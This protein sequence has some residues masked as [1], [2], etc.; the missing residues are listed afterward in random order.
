MH[1]KQSPHVK[2]KIAAGYILLAAV[3]C[4]AILYVLFEV[5][6][7]GQGDG[8]RQ[9]LH[10]RR[11]IVSRILYHLYQAESYGQLMT[12]GY[13][14][15]E[16]RYAREIRTVRGYLDSLRSVTADSV[17]MLRLDSIEYLVGQKERST[18][19]M[20]NS[21]VAGATS[22][23]LAENIERLL[24]AD[25]LFAEPVVRPDTV[26]RS[27][28]VR[29]RRKRR[30]F[31]RRLGDLF[32]PPREETGVVVST[33]IRI[34]TLPAVTDTI[35]GVLRTLEQRVTDQRL[36]IYEQAWKEGLRLR[37]SNRLVNE[38]IFRLI[39]AYE[40]DETAYLTARYL[41]A[42]AL[43]HRSS[44]VLG[45]IAAVSILLMLLFVAILWR[46]IGRANRYKRQIEEAN[47]TNEALIAA[48]EQMMRTIT[49]DIK[50]PLGSIMGYID[51][52][53]RLTGG[54][55][56][57]LYLEH[58]RSSADH[59]LALVNDLLD[60]Y[61]LEANKVETHSVPFDPRQ[62]FA[63]IAAEFAPQA[64]A[65]GIALRTELPAGG[66]FLAGDPFRIRQ[67]A[68]N[69]LSNALKFTDRGEVVLHV[70]AT[71]GE[72][73]FSVRDTGRGMSGE[74]RERIFGEFVRLR[75]A[76]G[77]DGFGLGLSIVDRLVKLL[78]G[79]VE[80]ESRKGEGSTFTVRLP[81]P[82]ADTGPCTP[83]TETRIA[84]PAAKAIR[85][86]IVDDDPL[87]SEMTAAM[88]G[89]LGAEAVCCPDPE[90]A[91]RLAE[92]QE[93]DL[94]LTDI[95]MPRMD[96]FHLLE[97]IRTGVRGRTLPAVA[98]TA[99]SDNRRED[100]LARGFADVLHKPF[101]R[102]E[103][104]RTLSATCKGA[105][106]C[107]AASDPEPFP[108]GFGTLTAFATGD[109][110]AAAAILRTFVEQQTA[111]VAALR[112]AAEAG[113]AK[114][115][116]ALAH[117][118]LP[119]FTMIGEREAATLLRRL[120]DPRAESAAADTTERLVEIVETVI[121]KAQN[122]LSLQNDGA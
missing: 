12:A 55:R 75:S 53:A 9:Q 25:S 107:G 43:R 115:L 66:R 36:A 6:N 3:S 19:R 100:Y 45:T 68:D 67:I 57:Q 48:R 64:S 85:C 1:M 88:L 28:T 2:A 86:L 56:E 96:G 82:D 63:S 71:D 105:S 72:L 29:I 83:V 81:A 8:Y 97:L 112:R 11:S 119:V 98:V 4:A 79:T 32:S 17:Q 15:D 47:R 87:Q 44:V 46:D 93:F 20:R 27:D 101:T 16:Q 10:S 80:V 42:A 38:Q 39:S 60:F 120:D 31:F 22:G 5:G 24:P 84:P 30:S 69:L 77:A 111:H 116:R 35:A 61:R 59:L 74:E 91:L 51:L 41:K 122:E 118:M 54:K 14:S 33:S 121:G 113:D 7:L 104:E 49:H 37:R 78:G 92:A 110:A 73:R 58:M 65:K 21:L 109:A 95:Q 70:G 103:L 106:V 52:L 117:K 114:T 89:S 18:L 13:S 102:T 76:A 26:V 50:A 62:L 23:L 108:A 99:R 34:D 90:G 94:L 40:E